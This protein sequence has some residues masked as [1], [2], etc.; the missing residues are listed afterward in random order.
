MRVELRSLQTQVNV[1]DAVNY[2]N[3]MCVTFKG[4]SPLSADFDHFSPLIFPPTRSL[5]LVKE[6]DEVTLSPQTLTR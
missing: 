6:E 3:V 5:Y 4:A 1:G 2:T